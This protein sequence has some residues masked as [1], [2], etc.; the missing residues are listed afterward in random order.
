MNQYV[1]SIYD[2]VRAHQPISPFALHTKTEGSLANLRAALRAALQTGL[3]QMTP[4]YELVIPVGSPAGPESA[5]PPSSPDAAGLDSSTDHPTPTQVPRPIGLLAT[6]DLPTCAVHPAIQTG[7]QTPCPGCAI[8]SAL[9]SL[10]RLKDE[11]N[12]YL[13][14]AHH[15]GDD[16]VRPA[17]SVLLRKVEAARQEYEAS[18]KWLRETQPERNDAQTPHTEVE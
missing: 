18:D 2:A 8:R 5:T 17:V 7:S 4:D 1:Q 10:L 15:L 3:V 6:T 16:K 13:L 11:L 9:S 14:A 12:K